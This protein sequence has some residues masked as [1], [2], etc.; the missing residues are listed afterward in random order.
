MGNLVGKITTDA[1]PLDDEI[2]CDSR[3]PSAVYNAAH[4]RVWRP[5]SVY[6]G[7]QPSGM[8]S[9]QRDETELM[10]R[11]LTL[12]RQ[13]TSYMLNVLTTPTNV[14]SPIL[15]AGSSAPSATSAYSTTLDVITD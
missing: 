11:T 14:S 4:R 3:S 2:N 10:M 15:D 7:A 1:G 13:A 9:A 8:E 6:I 12:W 5:N